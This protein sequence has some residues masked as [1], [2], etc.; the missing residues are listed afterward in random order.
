VTVLLPLAAATSCEGEQ[1]CHYYC[2]DNGTRDAPP[3]GAPDA[4]PCNLPACDPSECPPG[5]EAIA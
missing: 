5:C 2:I 4:T 3:P 1:E